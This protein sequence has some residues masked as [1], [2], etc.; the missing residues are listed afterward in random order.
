MAD[1]YSELPMLLSK[2]DI[3]AYVVSILD[4]DAADATRDT[5]QTADQ[6][7]EMVT[8]QTEIISHGPFDAATT[9]LID[10][11]LDRVWSDH[12]LRLLD[13]LTSLAVFTAG[14]CGQERLVQTR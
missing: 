12:P 5:Q 3:A 6:L 7:M 11:W 8:R 13:T 14:P 9:H 10:Q 2:E 4:A 1:F